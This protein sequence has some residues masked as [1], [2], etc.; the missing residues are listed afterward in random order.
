MAHKTHLL[1]R[2]SGI[3]LNKTMKSPWGSVWPAACPWFIL[4]LSDHSVLVICIVL[5]SN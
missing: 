4:V 2:L 1:G 3:N 5:L